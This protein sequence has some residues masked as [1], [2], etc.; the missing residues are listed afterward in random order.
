M[1]LT[2]DR[3]RSLTTQAHARAEAARTVSEQAAQ[4]KARQRAK[5]HRLLADQ[6]VERIELRAEKA[7]LR[8]ERECVVMRLRN[9]RDY[10]YAAPVRPE[11][12]MGVAR[13]VWDDLA[14]LPL[15]LREWDDGVGIKGG[16]DIVLQ[17]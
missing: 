11:T 6:I 5:R 14:H 10:T 12:L 1:A 2:L 7:A 13:L 17:W 9:P 8:E 16:W 3:L 4:Q 15:H